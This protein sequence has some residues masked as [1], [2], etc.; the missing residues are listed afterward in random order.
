MYSAARPV[1]PKPQ[2]KTKSDSLVLNKALPPKRRRKARQF[3]MEIDN[4]P[5]N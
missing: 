4:C 1:P 5:S 3:S 2:S